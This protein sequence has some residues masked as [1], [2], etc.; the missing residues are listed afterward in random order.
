MSESIIAHIGAGPMPAIST[1]LKPV[2]GPPMVLSP[3]VICRERVFIGS[4]SHTG[5]SDINSA[6]ASEHH[7][8]GLR[9]NPR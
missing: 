8:A 1:T 4:E 5:L 7:R 9:Y 3:L 6:D 2:N